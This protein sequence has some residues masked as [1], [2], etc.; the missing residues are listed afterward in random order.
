MQH[1]Y[2]GM[3][4]RSPFFMTFLTNSL[5]TIYLPTWYLWVLVGQRKRPT[6][7]PFV[8]GADIELAPISKT[9][10]H[11]YMDS[12]GKLPSSCAE[13]SVLRIALYLA[14]IYF[15]SNGF[16][17]YSILMTSISSSTIIR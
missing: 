3:D 13:I 8:N 11:G 5:L 1:V 4:F 12:S 2:N 14:P 10:N 17:N 6:V 16:Y 9:D 15:L 7:D